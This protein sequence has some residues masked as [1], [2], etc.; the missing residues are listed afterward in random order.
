MKELLKF[1]LILFIVVL[2]YSV[3]VYSIMYENTPLSFY[4]VRKVVRLGYWGLYGELFLEEE[5]GMFAT[6]MES[7]MQPTPSQNASFT[8]LTNGSNI[9][10]NQSVTVPQKE[11]IT[12]TS[13][14]GNMRKILCL[15]NLLL[16]VCCIKMYIFYLNISFEVMV[17]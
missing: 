3:T 14:I 5:D 7:I 15:R 6:P 16:D 1:V 4:L 10:T 8:F 13:P 12:N 2:A 11:N 17:S 9:S